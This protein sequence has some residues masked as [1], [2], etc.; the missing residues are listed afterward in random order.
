MQRDLVS[1]LLRRITA[2]DVRKAFENAEERG[3]NGQVPL[4]DPNQPQQQRVPT[5]WQT[6][7][8][9]DPTNVR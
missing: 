3:E 7:S 4:F 1:R 6:P 2:P 9:T 5:P 8:V